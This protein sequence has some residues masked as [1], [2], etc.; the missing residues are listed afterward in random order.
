MSKRRPSGNG[1]V[2]KREG[3]HREGCIV[4]GPKE[5]GK[6]IFRYI[7]AR[8]KAV[9]KNETWQDFDENAGTLK[10]VRAANAP[11]RGELEIDETKTS[12][13]QRAI[14]LPP[15]A[16]QRRGC[17]DALQY[18]GTHQ[19]VLRAGHLHSHYWGNVER[20]CTKIDYGLCNEIQKEYPQA[21]QNPLID[22]QPVTRCT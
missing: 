9:N 7:L 19:R 22:C 6:P 18:S 5:N 13:S 15:S 17:Q 20:G 2:R 21:K 10:I 4:V 12:Q 11:K 14:R 16:I 1:M 3:G 8:T